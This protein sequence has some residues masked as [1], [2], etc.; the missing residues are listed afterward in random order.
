[1]RVDG[2]R[3]I[4]QCVLPAPRH[5]VRGVV[6]ALQCIDDGAVGLAVT[7]A[8][9]AE[10]LACG[11]FGQAL[12]DIVE[13]RCYFSRR[14]LRLRGERLEDVLGRDAKAF[15]GSFY[16]AFHEPL[17]GLSGGVLYVRGFV[18]HGGLLEGVPRLCDAEPP[19]VDGGP[20]ADA[21][22]RVRLEG[23]EE[24]RRGRRGGWAA[25]PPEGV[26]GLAAILPPRLELG[27]R[28]FLAFL[29]L[30][31][32]QPCNNFHTILIGTLG[33]IEKSHGCRGIAAKSLWR[34]LA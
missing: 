7:R 28:L 22:L 16:T 29:P 24:G 23:L 13:R 19:E 30:R 8:D 20:G 9:L 21:P 27:A 14:G 15:G 25:E 1:M 17:Q 26:R 12:V 4:I 33:D 6:T 31:R 32:R 2:R 11:P 10:A 3:E 18:P 34:P 5:E